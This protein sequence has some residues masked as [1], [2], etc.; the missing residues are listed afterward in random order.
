MPVHYSTSIQYTEGSETCAV[1][2]S[3][4]DSNCIELVDPTPSYYAHICTDAGERYAQ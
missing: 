4:D 3:V 1:V 2:G